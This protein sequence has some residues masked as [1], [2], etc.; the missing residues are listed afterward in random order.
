M[1]ACNVRACAGVCTNS[2][3]MLTLLSPQLE[4]EAQKKKQL[5]QSADEEY[6]ARVA[7]TNAFLEKY[8]GESMP[9]ILAVRAYARVCVCL[10]ACVRVR[11]CAN[12]CSAVPA[13][14]ACD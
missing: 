10:F 13:V 3:L 11:V 9:R 12:F 8:Y 14:H 5:S 6:K 7:S 4:K 1:R 2:L